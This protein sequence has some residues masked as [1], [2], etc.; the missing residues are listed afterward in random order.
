MVKHTHCRTS[1]LRRISIR[2]GPARIEHRCVVADVAV[3]F[4]ATCHRDDHSACQAGVSVADSPTHNHN[5]R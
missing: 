1:E 2:M 4:C 5:Q 3:C